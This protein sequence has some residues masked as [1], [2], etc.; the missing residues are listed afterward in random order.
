MQILYLLFQALQS[1]TESPQAFWSAGGYWERLWGTGIFTAVILR[2]TVLSFVT[3]N[4][5]SSNQKNRIFFLI[6][7]RLFRRPSAYQEA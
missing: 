1:R 7:Q 6:R 4:S 3:V 5:Q 2:L